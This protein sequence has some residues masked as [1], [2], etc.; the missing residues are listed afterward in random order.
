MVEDA[1]ELSEVDV[2]NLGIATGDQHVLAICALRGSSEIGC[3]CNYNRM[4]A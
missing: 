2:G 4:V 1:H 3:S